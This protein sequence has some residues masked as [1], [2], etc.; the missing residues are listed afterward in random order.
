METSSVRIRKKPPWLKVKLPSHHNFFYVSHLLKDKRLNTICQSAKC[1]NISECWAHKTATFLIFGDTCTRN[2]SFCAVKKG[3]PSPLSE[4]ESEKVAEAVAVL[5]LHY[6]V[7]TSVTRDDLPDGGAAQFART[8]AAVKK[9]MPETKLEVLIPDFQ[10]NRKALRTV[11]AAGP[12]I[13]N[14]NIEVPKTIYPKI[15]RPTENYHRSLRIL[16]YAKELGAT[17]KSGIMVGLGETREDILAT[18]SDLRAVSC[19]LLTIGQ[20]LQPTK[21]NAPVQKYYTPGE[22]ED[23]KK[24]AIKWGFKKV[25]SGP[26]VRSSFRAERM[27][28][29][30]NTKVN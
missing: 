3:I 26:L 24:T 30:T 15:K 20:Y 25:E 12:D 17:T 1:P 27:Y 6:A 23:L 28:A 18:F 19:D 7:I 5:G 14:H 22:F 2:C 11:I 13:L 10:G 29:A 9:R 8:L 4:S 16:E 21:S